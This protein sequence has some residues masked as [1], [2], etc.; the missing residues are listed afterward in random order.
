[1]RTATLYACFSGDL[2]PRV[3]DTRITGHPSI[4]RSGKDIIR[5]EDDL[6][7]GS[8]D[9]TIISGSDSLASEKE[10]IISVVEVRTVPHFRLLY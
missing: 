9:Q 1:L 8:P 10:G 3:I 4:T 5:F 6:P 7:T 2:P